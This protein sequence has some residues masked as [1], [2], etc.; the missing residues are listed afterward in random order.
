MEMAKAR[1][2]RQQW[3]DAAVRAIARGG[4]ASVAVDALAKEFGITRGSFYWHFADRDELLRAALDMWQRA[5]TDDIIA[6]LEAIDDPRQRLLALFTTAVGA[7]G[8]EGFE[9]ALAAD[10]SHPLVAPVLARVTDG[11][12]DYLTSVFRQAGRDPATARRQAVTAYAIYVGWIHLRHTN[13]T[14]VPELGSGDAQGTTTVVHVV[15]ILLGP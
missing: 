15:D 5:G 4:V 11:R 10:A 6:A 7:D 12:L 2:T 3:I 1:V 14:L 9:V 13:P 8:V